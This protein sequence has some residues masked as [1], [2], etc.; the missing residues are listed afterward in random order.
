[1][2]GFDKKVV[3]N[4][5]AVFAEALAGDC[6]EHLK[7]RIIRALGQINWNGKPL[8]ELFQKF[9]DAPE[10]RPSLYYSLSKL[11]GEQAAQLIDSRL[12]LLTETFDGEEF[13]HLI[14]CVSQMG[15]VKDPARLSSFADNVPKN[16]VTNFLKIL[17]HNFVPGTEKIVQMGLLN[18]DFQH[19]MLALAAAKYNGNDKIWRIALELKEGKQP[20]LAGRALDSLCI[21]GRFKDHKLLLDAL[22][23]QPHNYFVAMKIFRSLKPEEKRNYLPI[24]RIIDKHLA[25]GSGIFADKEL[26][27][28]ATNLRDNLELAEGSKKVAKRH[29]KALKDH[30]LDLALSKGIEGFS[31]YSETVKSILR[32]AELTYTHPELFDE[33]VDKSTIVVEYVK[34]IDLLLQEKIGSK[35]FLTGQTSK[36]LTRM[37]SRLVFMQ[38]EGRIPKTNLIRDLQ[39]DYH[40]SADEFP[41]HKMSLLSYAITSGKIQ[42]DQYRTID[43]LRAWAILLLLFGRDFKFRSQAIKPIFAVNPANN[44]KICKIAANLNK[45]Q[46]MRNDAAHRGTML[47]GD[48]IEAIRVASFGVLTEL[49]RV[50]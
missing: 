14:N 42:H 10:L 45:L 13:D 46:V 23:D 33:R 11:K 50:L 40:F 22:T 7:L 5:G 24:I 30:E 43:G 8:W 20:C 37:Q 4:L 48:I 34:S 9:F 29:L 1:M 31:L 2:N 41:G 12:A 47:K 38:L 32:N 39:C 3:E 17:A 44:A 49:N 25:K 18:D 35:I 15:V 27:E 16:R 6:Q 28:A 21:G 26:V 19:K 36:I